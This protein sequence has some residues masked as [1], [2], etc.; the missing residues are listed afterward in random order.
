MGQQ[1][2]SHLPNLGNTSIAFV[3]GQLD[4]SDILIGSIPPEQVYLI[5][6][7]QN[8]IEQITEILSKYQNLES[9]HIFS[10][11]SE[12]TLQLGNSV[13]NEETLGSYLDDL[14]AW[15]NALTQEGD[16]LFYGCNLAAADGLDFVKQISQIT[17]A[18]VAASNDITGY[19]KLGGDWE[20]EAVTGDIATTLAIDTYQGILDSSLNNG[21]PIRITAIGDSIT[22]AG[23]GHNS[24]R[25][26]LWNLL[27]ESGY[28]VDFVG[29]QN[30]TFDGSPFVD[31][32]FDPDHEGHWGWRVDEI[33]NGLSGWL[34]EYTPDV[35]LIHLGS[36][37]I[38]SI[39][40]A[41]STV[42]ELG[43][44]VNLLRADNPDIAVFIA[45]IIPTFDGNSTINNDRNQRIDEFNAL[46]PTLIAELN[47][48]NSPVVLVDQNTGFDARQDTF[49][50]I[51]PNVSGEAKMAQNW[52]DAFTSVF[53][54]EPTFS[55]QNDTLS[56]DEAAGEVTVTVVRS[57]DTQDA[58]TIEYTLNGVGT[59]SAT[60]DEDY[61]APV[62]AGQVTFAPGATEATISIPILN[63]ALD[64]GNESF[65]VTLQNPSIGLIGASSSTVVTIMDDDALPTLSLSQPSI[66][67]SETAGTASITVERNGNPNTAVSVSYSINNGTAVAGEDYIASSG[68]LEFAIG[69]TTQTI[70]IPISDDSVDEDPET[71][72]VTLGTPI[73]AELGNQ[74]SAL[75][76]I[77][78]NDGSIN[79][80][81]TIEIVAIGDSITQAGPG[82]NSY[83]RDLWNL[84]ND[85]GY[86]V[87]F[88]GSEN[89]TFDGSP[90]IDSSFDPDHEGHWGWRVDE[91]NNGLSGW[92][93]GYTPDI[94]L[95]HLGSADLFSL[96]SAESTVD[97]LRETINIL[98]ADNPDVNVFLAQVI[99]TT[100]D[101]RNARIAEFNA[102]LPAL[103][104][105]LS[106]PNSQV[107]V[108]DQN[109]GFDAS[110]DT[111]DGI[112]PNAGGEAKMAQNWFDAFASVF[113][114]QPTK[115]SFTLQSDT[116][117]VDEF[118]QEATITVIRSGDT[119]AAATV[120]YSLR[121]VGNN[122]ATAGDDFT[123]PVTTGQVSFAPG[124]TEATIS[125]PILN[126]TF[127]EGNE[128]LVVE[129]QNPS[130][131]LLGASTST[132]VTIVDDDA[133][134]TLSLGQPSITV[135]ETATTASITVERTGNP[136]TAV[137][138]AYA[139]TNGTATAGEDYSETTG[140]LEFAIGQ[141]SQ[142]IEIPISDDTTI[143]GTEAFSIRLLNPVDA[144][145]GD[146]STATVN[147]TDNDGGST[148]GETIEIVTIGDSITQTGPGF[149]SYR[150]DLWNLL[151]DAGYEVDFVG[152]ENATF[153]GSPFLDNTFDPDHEGHWGW[154]VD[155]I[156][157]GRGGE[158]NLAE[159]LTGYTPDVALIHLGTNDLFNLQSAESTIDD[160]RETVNILRADNS[161]VTIFLAQLIPTTDN[162][163]NARI[164]EFNALL[165]NLVS[166]L[167][168]PNS[169]VY[170]VNQNAGFD[171][172]QDTFDG[173]H[174]NA[175]GEAKMAQRWFDAFASNFSVSTEPTFS[176]QTDTLSVD[177]YGGNATITVVRSGDTQDAATVDY[178][179][180][181]V[182][183][184]PATAD[185]DFS[186]PVTVGQVTFAPGA[187][188]A[189]L[190]IPILND[191][192]DE[193]NESFVVELLNPSVGILGATNSTLVT[194]V[195][196]DA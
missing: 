84:L 116:L 162:A 86:D 38:F 158:G 105:E 114:V 33:N 156:N 87:D 49:D 182:G 160:L 110:Q 24:Y 52:F 140:I 171:A 125:I 36:A 121:G 95:I 113:T 142:T 93:T 176:V 82:F 107:Y 5:D 104:A 12:G 3:D 77:L 62:T 167:N 117:S 180:R 134:P 136:N 70:E 76:T 178:A 78:D 80:G 153:D 130:V 28:N 40:S 92:L 103:A 73:N 118:A 124:E 150:R 147:I 32:T 137:S 141:T 57:G 123:A 102:L 66:S 194:I 168:Q 186:A 189:T 143:E 132:L 148:I 154:R 11:G 8:G 6:D 126:D 179:L 149:N 177:E 53:P 19:A 99:P 109:T 96:Q 69:Q 43:E 15:G 112:N 97:E 48:T 2:N 166:E 145:L 20:L 122:A 59:N 74:S 129:L 35:A 83:R 51:N 151:N 144:E 61:S 13:L 64:E 193:G 39:Q 185:A 106:Q 60:P 146:Q 172:S 58:A 120:E 190:S 37:D 139:T 7:Q 174:P 17:Q 16:L 115:P 101:D 108:V 133:L 4:Q 163:R 14:E 26:D 46:L 157:N 25:R 135:L 98:R 9:I 29:S 91:I 138:V 161:N 127:I 1:Q 191:S 44:T 23:P 196:D 131:G 119:Q 42:D 152:S 47:Q 30:T 45:Q 173:I 27:N 169:P 54:V 79:V 88:V 41:E 89:A 50:G 63:D 55:V 128:T 56:I 90:F 94:A 155:E 18:D 165:P 67:V 22:Q 184:N 81:E 164:N 75:V 31:S 21:E 187:T 72:V 68:T 100:N 170:L 183:N 34:T 181:G 111:F 159:W 71:F 65:S 10:H 85:A 195:D 175:G 192:L 188:V